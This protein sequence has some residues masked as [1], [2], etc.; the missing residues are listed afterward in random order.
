MA[1]IITINHKGARVDGIEA[2]IERHVKAKYP[3]TSHF[4]PA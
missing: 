2:L 4:S 3:D 1:I